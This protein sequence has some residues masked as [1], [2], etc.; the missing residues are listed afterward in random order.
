[1]KK[2]FVALL[3]AS[4]MALSLSAC[5]GSGSDSSS[6]KSDTKKEETVK[7][8]KKADKAT[9]EDSSDKQIHPKVTHL[10][11]ETILLLLHQIHKQHLR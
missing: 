8:D 10:I 1:M 3:L 6:S 2:K 9:T 7:S 11:K 5:G 4:S